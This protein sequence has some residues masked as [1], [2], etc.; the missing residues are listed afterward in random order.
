MID[1]HCHILPMVDDGAKSIDEA[2]NMLIDAYNDNTD[3]IVLTPHFAFSYG[4]I[5]P[6]EKINGLFHDLKYIVD[7]ER[8]PIDM[9]LGCEYLFDSISTYKHHIHEIAKMNKTNYLLMEFFFDVNADFVLEAIDTV[10]DSGYIPIIAHPERYECIQVN[11][12][13][14]QYMIDH[15][16]LLQMNK[17]SIFNQYGRNARKCVLDMLDH[18][19]I[20]FVGS[21][22]H[23]TIN[24]NSLMFDDYLYVC[25][26]YGR[27]YAYKIFEDNPERMLSNSDIRK[28]GN[29]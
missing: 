3:K 6:Y 9:Y 17:G 10:I 4:F 16:A 28:K 22:A 15:G 26:Y 5:N 19:Y 1:I 14:P 20:S 21:D 27:D 18:H 13:L 23:N 24:R 11:S 12:S 25:D 29:R 7:N 8:I 2:I